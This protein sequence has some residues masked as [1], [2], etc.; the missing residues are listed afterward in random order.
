MGLFEKLKNTFFE[1]EYVEV[2]EETPKKEDKKEK[3]KVVDMG[4]INTEEVRNRTK[5][6]DI[7]EEKIDEVDEL[8][9]LN[10]LAVE[11]ETSTISDREL[12]NKNNKIE[13]FNDDDFVTNDY[14]KEEKTEPKKI[15]GGE[16]TN[17]TL[18]NVSNDKKVYNKP[19]GASNDKGFQ[20]TPII[21]PIYGV[22]DKNYRKDEVIDKKDRP[23]SYVS[24]KNADLDSVRQKAYG[25][26]NMN[27]L[28]SYD[29][30]V[31]DS[32]IDDTKDGLLDDVVEESN[33]P[34]VDKV[35][36]A[37]AE[38]YFEDLGLEYNVDYK[39]AVYE[40]A[41]GRRT[42]IHEYDDDKT[43]EII[44]NDSLSKNEEK[45]ETEPEESNLLEDNLFDLV[46]S[47]YEDGDDE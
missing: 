39:D 44:L 26:S 34:V 42:S 21:S 3:T 16:Y 40:K 10:T 35:S 38:Q 30:I 36:I 6:E 46:D 45:V 17:S 4:S 13:Y 14:Y 18:Y 15:Y 12:V 43:Q 2:D 20:P 31:N 1:E 47:I 7:P 37:D 24:K 5:I 11:A 9:E 32:I 29:E 25:F 27:D 8:D 19:Y 22:L 28:P 41:N 33:K 23:S